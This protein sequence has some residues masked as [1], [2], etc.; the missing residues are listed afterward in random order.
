MGMMLDGV[1]K[2]KAGWYP[3]DSFCGVNDIG[4]ELRRSADEVAV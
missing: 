3:G 1:L 4:T 2:I